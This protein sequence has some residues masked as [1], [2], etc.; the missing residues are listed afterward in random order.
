MLSDQSHIYDF[1]TFEF[2]GP[3]GPVIFKSREHSAYSKGSLQKLIGSQWTVT[4]ALEWEV[5]AAKKFVVGKFDCS[6]NP[7]SWIT[8]MILPIV[9]L[10]LLAYFSLV[11]PPTAPMAMPRV[12]L[13]LLAMVSVTTLYRTVTGSTP[14]GDKFPKAAEPCVTMVY[15]LHRNSDVVGSNTAGCDTMHNLR[16]S[17]ACN[18]LWCNQVSR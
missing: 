7:S 4:S 11:L 17:S 12:A 15:A 16:D 1:S 10:T 3:D 13:S 2:L 8:D 18:G 14:P 6:R 9:T 5:L